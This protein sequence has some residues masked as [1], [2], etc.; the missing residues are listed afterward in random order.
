MQA[1]LASISLAQ[2][3]VGQPLIDTTKYELMR[4]FIWS[5]PVYWQRFSAVASASAMERFYRP[6][7]HLHDVV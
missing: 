7:A 4:H 6:G 2:C 3:A 5:V 1:L